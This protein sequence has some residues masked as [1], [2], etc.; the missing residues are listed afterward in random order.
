MR[1][2][3]LLQLARNLPPGK[4]INIMPEEIREAAGEGLSHLDR[5]PR[6]ED[7]TRF[8]EQVNRD[9]GVSLRENM[10]KGLYTMYKPEEDERRP[11]L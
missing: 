1:Q 8:V 6:R 5:P 9:W 2:V 11:N 3:N 7:V 10:S 4:S